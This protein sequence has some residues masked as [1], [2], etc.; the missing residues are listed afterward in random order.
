[1]CWYMSAIIAAACIPMVS[2]RHQ[3]WLP[4]AQRQ[5]VDARSGGA[6]GVYVT[7]VVAQGHVFTSSPQ[8]CNWFSHASAMLLYIPPC[9]T[10]IPFIA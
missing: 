6:S 10:C 2:G 9:S 5:E 8:G 1:M 7:S 3:S 4:A